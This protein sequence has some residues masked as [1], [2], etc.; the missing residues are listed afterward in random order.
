M[1][2]KKIRQ[3]FFP[4]SILCQWH[5]TRCWMNLVQ[6][7]AWQNR[8]TSLFAHKILY[9]YIC[10]TYQRCE[11]N[12]FTINN[13]NSAI[14]DYQ[15]F[16]EQCCSVVF[17]LNICWRFKL[18]SSR[19]FV[20]IDRYVV[21]VHASALGQMWCLCRRWWWWWYSLLYVM[22]CTRCARGLLLN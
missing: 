18:L 4:G 3:I 11:I 13:I 20:Y 14:P 22:C 6:C 5:I 21:T 7:S 9:L 2:L 17:W 16:E 10:C 19:I 1:L 15:L 8:F 12:W